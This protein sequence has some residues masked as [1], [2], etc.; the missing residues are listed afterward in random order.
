[1]SWL[2]QKHWGKVAAKSDALKS[3]WSAIALQPQSAC[4]SS[5]ALEKPAGAG[6]YERISAHIA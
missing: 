4:L 6:K 1:M 5:C 2:E 3:I